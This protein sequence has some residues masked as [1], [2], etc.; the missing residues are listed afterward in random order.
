MEDTERNQNLHQDKEKDNYEYAEGENG[1]QD[2]K[3]DHPE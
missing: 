2:M 1:T 3:M